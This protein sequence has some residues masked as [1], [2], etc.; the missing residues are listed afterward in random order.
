MACG[1]M[2]MVPGSLHED[3]RAWKKLRELDAG[4]EE[5][6]VMCCGVWTCPCRKFFGEE[7]F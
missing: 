6:S 2:R 7:G 1:M 5:S 3:R 4:G